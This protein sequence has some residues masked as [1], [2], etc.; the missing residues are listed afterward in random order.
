MFNSSQIITQIMQLIVQKYSRDIFTK[1]SKRFLYI[2]DTL[3]SSWGENEIFCIIWTR[4][5][6]NNNA[7][8]VSHVSRHVNLIVRLMMSL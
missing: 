3:Q 2:L 8:L 6:I 7:S 5:K 4:D 1:W